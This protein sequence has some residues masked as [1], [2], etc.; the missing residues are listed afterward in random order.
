MAARML[1]QM[2]VHNPGWEWNKTNTEAAINRINRSVHSGS[3]ARITSWKKRS[4]L[5]ILAHLPKQCKQ[6]LYREYKEWGWERSWMT[7]DFMRQGFWLPGHKLKVSSP[8]QSVYT[9]TEV[10]LEKFIA[11]LSAWWRLSAPTGAHLQVYQAAKPWKQS[12]DSDL[13]LD[14]MSVGMWK[15]ICVCVMWNWLVPEC[16]RAFGQDSQAVLEDLS[17]TTC[18]FSHLIPRTCC[19]G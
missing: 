6:A 14:G 16:K 8:W 7:E 3:D 19:E 18:A 9:V 17:S 11:A 5:N 1:E 13:S 2:Q 10:T 12:V 15:L 4:V